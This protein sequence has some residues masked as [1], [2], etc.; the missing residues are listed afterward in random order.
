M[1]AFESIKAHRVHPDPSVEKKMGLDPAPRGSYQLL[2]DWASGETSWVNYQ[3]IFKDDPVSVSLYAQRN[4]LL[5]T[6][7]WKNC[8][9]YIR[10]VKVLARM[11]NQVKLRTHRMRPKYK[12]GVQIPRSHE[13]AV[14]ID[15]KD[16]NTG[17]Q[18]AEKVESISSTSTTPSLIL[19]RGYHSRRIQEDTLP[20]S[21]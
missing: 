2:V 8:K 20:H 3:I 17:W 12:Y 18:D 16:G 6:P 10:N 5:S 15:T 14:W 19:E 1:F 9:R 4:G 7:G 13:E 11:A 21:L